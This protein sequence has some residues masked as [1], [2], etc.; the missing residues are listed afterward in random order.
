MTTCS[1]CGQENP[2]GARFCNAC[3]TPLKAPTPQVEVRKTVTVLFT[4][5]TGSTSLGERLDPEALRHVMGRYFDAMEAVVQRH[6]GTVEKFIGDAVMAVFGV[7]TL[8]EDDALRAVRAAAEMRA[9]LRDLNKE[10]ERDVGVTIVARTG[11]NTG[12]VVAGDPRGGQRLATGDA[13]NVAAR[14]EQ[15][16]SPGDILI[17]DQTYRLTRAAVVVQPVEPLQ[18]KGKDERVPAYRL[19]EVIADAPGFERRLESAMVGRADELDL[20]QRAFG[21]AGRE[22]TSLLFT[23]LGSAGVGK[24]RLVQEFVTSVGDDGLVLRGRCLAYGEGI[25]YW[26]L[27]DIVKQA[28]EITE[29]DPPE[30]ALARIAALVAHEDRADVIAEHV[31]EAIGVAEGTAPPEEIAWAVRRLFETLARHRPVVVVFDDIHWAEPSL[32]D[33]IEHVADWSRGAPILLLCLA[34]QELLDV[35]PAWGGGKLNA[36]T[37]QLE[38]LTDSQS[39]EL[40]T[41][42]LGRSDLDER[43]R[44]R[45]AD[46]AE[47]NPLFV[48]QM[49]SMLIDDGLLAQRDGRWVAVHPLD[50][51]AVPPTIHALVAARLDRLSADERSVIERA[52]IEG[53]VFHVGAVAALA[54]EEMKPNVLR[55]LMA[56]TRREL[57]RPDQAELRGEEA[58][59]FRHQLIR[60]ATYQATPKEVRAD[61]HER[62]ADWLAERTADRSHEYEEIVGYHLER[63]FAYRR[64]LGQSGQATSEIGA[65]AGTILASA[66][67]RALARGDFPAATNLLD[68]ASAVVPRNGPEFV[69]ISIDL[70]EAAL[71]IGRYEVC[72][73]AADD[74]VEA[75][76][77]LGDEV[78]LARAQIALLE[79]LSPTD[80]E[81]LERTGPDVVDRAI[82]SLEAAGDD[83]GLARAWNAHSELLAARADRDRMGASMQKALDH[84]RKAGDLRFTRFLVVTLIANDYWGP[85]PADEGLR[86]CAAALGEV[87][88]A[89]GLRGRVKFAMVGFLGMQ[90]RFDEARQVVAE[91]RR[92]SEEL[93]DRMALDRLGFV[94]GPMELWAGRP[95][96]AESE[97]RSNCLALMAIG[98][99]TSLCSLACFLAEAIYV[100]GRYDEA[101][102]WVSRGRE[103][104]SEDDVEAQSDWRCIRAKILARQGSFH[105]AEALARE[106]LELAQQTDEIDHIGDAWMDVA[107][108]LRLA[109]RAEEASAAVR[110]AITWYERKGNKAAASNARRLLEEG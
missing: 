74:A 35:R 50:D 42:L 28:A 106:G 15:A 109:G 98:D 104:A 1:N 38:P 97:L 18:L 77:R 82:R 67:R 79:A 65:R 89:P 86:R 43:V 39:G 80:P 34:R 88:D 23:A 101:D 73:R 26:P 93:G 47:G 55:H 52:A 81:E 100:Q 9:D 90:E 17:G 76:G 11:V 3:A 19:V 49:V 103:T 107:E 108:V 68:R 54:P 102:A 53:K 22:R 40:V 69:D 96:A 56:M 10:L 92:T 91:L 61:L 6:G 2:D 70:Q 5:V 21:R 33:L 78:R 7:P 63:A 32:L 24:S 12:E 31:A 95:E 66:G 99:R 51:V 20:L 60:D 44:A 94:V 29:H 30:E 37:I 8:H 105:A 14:L 25:T 48:E 16:A 46:A 27:V 110:E 71:L 72:R 83:R 58:F 62:F 57:V 59:R 85:L 13:V 4:D 41:N 84:A 75:A 36:T 64:E 45:I 87:E